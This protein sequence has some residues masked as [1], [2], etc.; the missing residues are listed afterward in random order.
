M[1]N[2]IKQYVVFSHFTI[3]YGQKTIVFNIEEEINY[4]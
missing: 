3:Y 1:K 2:E 4:E